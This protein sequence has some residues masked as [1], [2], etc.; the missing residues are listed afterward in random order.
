MFEKLKIHKLAKKEQEKQ[1]EIINLCEE[2]TALY[3]FMETAKLGLDWKHDTERF[4][5][6]TA[7]HT[8]NLITHTITLTK[9]TWSLIG[10]T[11]I[12]L[13]LILNMTFKWISV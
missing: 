10:L 2:A 13:F 8:K 6:F 3:N 12:H 7:A 5:A 1:K 4:M 11:L 9:L